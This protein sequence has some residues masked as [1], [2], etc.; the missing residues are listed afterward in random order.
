MDLAAACCCSCCTLVQ[1][2]KEAQ[3]RVTTQPI[4]TGYTNE[5]DMTFPNKDTPE[6]KEVPAA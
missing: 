6:T 5:A 2:E 3:H 4:D 1:M